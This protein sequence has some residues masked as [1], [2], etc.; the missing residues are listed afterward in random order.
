MITWMQLELKQIRRGTKAEDV[1]TS[2]APPPL[3]Y[4]H[5]P[6]LFYIYN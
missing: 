6:H 4:S 3:F 5:S 2:L 1:S